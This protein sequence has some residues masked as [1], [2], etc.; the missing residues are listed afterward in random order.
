MNEHTKAT[1]NGTAAIGMKEI[2][3]IFGIFPHNL[4]R[5]RHVWCVHKSIVTKD[6][7]TRLHEPCYL[8]L[9]EQWR[10]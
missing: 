9:V 1:L 5:R 10:G 7:Q 3:R 4:V 2:V 8:Q 6:A